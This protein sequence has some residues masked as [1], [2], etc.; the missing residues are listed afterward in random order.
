MKLE[1]CVPPLWARSGH[2]QTLLGHLIPSPR[3]SAGGERVEIPLPDGDRLIGRFFGGESK[4]VVYFFH[5]LGGHT[6]ADYMHRSAKVAQKL[7]HSVFLMNHR[8][9]GEGRGFAK[10]PYHSGRGE[11]LSSVIAHGRSRFPKHRHL[12]VGF[13]LSGNALLVL[14][15]GLRG[16]VKPD[17]A[18]TVNAPINLMSASKALKAGLNRIYDIRFV[19]ECRREIQLRHGAEG[20]RRFKVPVYSTLYDFDNLYTAPASG[21]RDREDYY[22]T[23]STMN[24]LEK[25]TTP[26]IVMT[27]Q[28]DPFVHFEHYR[29]AKL[30]PNVSLHSE[31]VGGHMGYLSREKTPLGSKRWLDYAIFEAIR[32]LT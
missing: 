19:L 22:E 1:A 25:I 6:D 5:G 28:D 32:E 17:A 3:L 14:L 13:S 23:C 31:K 8:G 21:F 16:D 24:H 11:D 15:A 2:S 4:T 12:A 18:V 30:S 10:N 29:A 9:C 20:A 7:G 26:T 27:A